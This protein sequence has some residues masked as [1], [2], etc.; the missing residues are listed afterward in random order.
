[1]SHSLVTRNEHGGRSSHFVHLDIQLC[2]VAQT[3]KRN[4]HSTDMQHNRL[5]NLHC[6]KQFYWLASSQVKIGLKITKEKDKQK[7]LF[8]YPSFFKM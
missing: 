7:Q 1:M 2:L 5:A 8:P 6:K 4:N 3:I